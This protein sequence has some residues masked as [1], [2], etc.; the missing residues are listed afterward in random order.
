[1]KL[2]Y[3]MGCLTTNKPSDFGAQLSDHHP[4][5]GIFNRIYTT[6]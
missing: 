5:P 4:D 2:V 1:M 3:E 6:V